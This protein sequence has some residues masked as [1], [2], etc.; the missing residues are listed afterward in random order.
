M[1]QHSMGVPLRKFGILKSLE[2]HGHHRVPDCNHYGHICNSY[3]LYCQVKFYT[4]T[5]V[6]VQ[7]KADLVPFL[8]PWIATAVATVVVAV[9]FLLHWLSQSLSA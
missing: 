8:P 7:D 3:F 5:F 4:I 6:Q 9:L 1:V 2:D